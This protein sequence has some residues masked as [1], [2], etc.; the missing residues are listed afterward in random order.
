MASLT[1]EN[2]REE[3]T[4][5]AFND[6]M[7]NGAMAFVPSLAGLWLAMKNPKFRKVTNSQSRTAIAIMPPLFVFAVTAEQKLT[8]RMHEVASE[9]EHNIQ[10]IAWA[11]KKKTASPHDIHLHDLYRQSIVESGVR[12]VDTPTLSTYQRSANFVQGNPFKCIGAIGAPAVAYIFYGQ[13]GK[14]GGPVESFQMRLLHTRVFGQFAVICT[15]LG[16]MSLKEVMDRYGRYV[17]EDE[18]ND[19]IK[20]MEDTRSRLMTK[21]EYQTYLQRRLSRAR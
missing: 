14:V 3:V 18:I 19:R 17:T 12:I 8:H 1:P 13:G 20:E 15:L 7:I 4:A 6:G 2:K 21:A 16:V 10:T 9:S 11:D 5:A